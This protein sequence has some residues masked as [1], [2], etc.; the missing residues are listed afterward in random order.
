MLLVAIPFPVLA[1]SDATGPHG[2]LKVLEVN[3]TRVPCSGYEGQTSCL[4]VRS[5]GE[6][7][8]GY[9]YEPIDG[10]TTEAGYR[11]RIRVVTTT[12]PYPPMDAP[13]LRYR[14]IEVLSREQLVPGLAR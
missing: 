8:W 12:V 5:P 6:A 2:R 10:F 3:G 9:L 13:D 11:Y 14:L 7:E 4:L 1:C